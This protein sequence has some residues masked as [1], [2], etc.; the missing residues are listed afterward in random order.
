METFERQIA[1]VGETSESLAREVSSL[2]QRMGSQ[3]AQLVAARAAA[4][5]AEEER[6]AAKQA[7]R[8]A[9]AEAA[10]LRASLET[11]RTV[12]ATAAIAADEGS[13]EERK[14]WQAEQQRMHAQV[15]SLTKALAERERAE[16]QLRA[17]VSGTLTTPPHT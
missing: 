8:E 5:R 3:E 1:S 11:H 10:T 15:A 7:A 9:Q 12:A 16:E 13:V 14:A 4:T 17:E 6:D 2:H